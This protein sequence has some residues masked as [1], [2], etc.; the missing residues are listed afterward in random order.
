MQIGDM[1]LPF[2]HKVRIDK[3]PVPA[4]CELA[5]SVCKEV[6]IMGE[7]QEGQV[8]MITTVSDPAE[9]LWYMEAARFGIMTGGVEDE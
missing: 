6:I 8:H 7:N 9:I 4:V 5:G 3:E 1:G 2:V